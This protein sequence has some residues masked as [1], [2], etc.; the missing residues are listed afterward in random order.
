MLSSPHADEETEAQGGYDKL[1]DLPSVHEEV[2]EL[3]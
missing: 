1:G 2:A 3:R